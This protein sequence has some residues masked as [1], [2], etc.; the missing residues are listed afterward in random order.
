VNSYDGHNGNVTAVGFQ[1]DSKWMFSGK[2]GFHAAKSFRQTTLLA[3]DC[4]FLL[5]TC[6]QVVRM[7]LYVSGICVLQGVSEPMRA[8]QLSTQWSCIPT[9]ES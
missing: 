3:A 7:A 5:F 6:A 8:G 2:W 9:K 1:K 4:A